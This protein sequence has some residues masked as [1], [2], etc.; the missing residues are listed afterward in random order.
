LDCWAAAAETSGLTAPP[1]ATESAVAEFLQ[2]SQVEIQKFPR[3]RGVL[4]LGDFQIRTPEA[5]F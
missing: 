5:W 4:G 3:F 1:T 2:D